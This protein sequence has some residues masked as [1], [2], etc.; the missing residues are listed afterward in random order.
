MEEFWSQEDEDDL[1]RLSE[2]PG[3]MRREFPPSSHDSTCLGLDKV[4]HLCC[5]SERH[6]LFQFLFKID[7]LCYSVFLF[8]LVILCASEMQMNSAQVLQ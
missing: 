2:R 5:V 1:A 8:S 3:V 6:V 7:L 4:L